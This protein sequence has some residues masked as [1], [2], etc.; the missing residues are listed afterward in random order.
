[1][2]AS[3]LPKGQSTEKSTDGRPLNMP[4]IYQHKDTGARFITAEG[5]S[6]VIQA[7][8]LMTERWKDAWKRV[9]DVPSRLEL[10]EMRKAQELKDAKA[11]AIEKAAHK[12]ELKKAV[13][14]A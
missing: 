8:A 10:L 6:G 12:A 3:Q 9:G 7:D 14:L 1:M 13:A 4:G 11:D 2:D 5:E